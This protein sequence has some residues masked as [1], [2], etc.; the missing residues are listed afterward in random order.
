MKE[1][2]IDEFLTTHQ[3]EASNAHRTTLWDFKSFS[4][5]D[6]YAIRD[7]KKASQ[8]NLLWAYLYNIGM[9]EDK[10]KMFIYNYLIGK[11]KTIFNIN[12]FNCRENV[13]PARWYYKVSEKLPERIEFIPKFPVTELQYKDTIGHLKF[14]ELREQLTNQGISEKY[15]IDYFQ[16]KNITSKRFNPLTNRYCYKILPQQSIIIKLRD[17]INPDYWYIF[18]EELEK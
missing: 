5:E 4:D 13:Q 16:L 11:N 1:I 14:F 10:M 18:P 7:L 2:N 6:S 12:V 3:D 8:K 15:N 17:V 9:K